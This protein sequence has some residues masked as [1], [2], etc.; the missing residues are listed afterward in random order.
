MR[1]RWSSSSLSS[2]HDSRRIR[3]VVAYDGTDIAG[4]QW[5]PGRRTVQGLLQEG[6][7]KLTGEQVTVTGAGRT[8]AGVHASGQVLH[9]D[10]RW[11]QDLAALRRGW[12]AVLPRDVAIQALD[13]APPGFHA[14]FSAL[15]RSYSYRLLVRPERDPLRRR[16]TLWIGKALDLGVMQA[17]AARLVGCHDFGGFGRPMRPGGS[18]VR[19]MQLC[20]LQ[21]EGDEWVLTLRANA[22]L[23]HQVRRMVGALIDIGR[24]QA[25]LEA[26]D[27]TLAGQASEL[28][29][30][31]VPPQGL[32]LKSVDYPSDEAI[33]AA[34]SR[35]PTGDEDDDE[36][37]YAEGG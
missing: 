17:A 26:L 28:R 12:N 18:T 9:F 31:R 23:R 4:F 7:L 13:E 36:D 32:V 8:D 16:F 5:Q 24:G 33:A 14:R 15:S 34:L 30:R 20:Q 29:P 21:G 3:A 11:S 35:V 10:S 37:L 27:Q 2:L 6:L 22:F 25:S 19:Q 1:P